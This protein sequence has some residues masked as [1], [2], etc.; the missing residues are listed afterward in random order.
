MKK[1]LKNLNTILDEKTNKLLPENLK[2]GVTL[3]G[4]EGTLESSNTTSGIIYYKDFSAMEA[5]KTQADG[6]L[7][8][9]GLNDAEIGVGS[10]NGIE[11]I[12][13]IEFADTIPATAIDSIPNDSYNYFQGDGLLFQPGDT[14]TLQI[15]SDNGMDGE[16]HITALYTKSGDNYTRNSDASKIYDISILTNY[17]YRLSKVYWESEEAKTNLSPY[18]KFKE[19][20]QTMVYVFNKPDN[21]WV[22]VPNTY[23]SGITSHIYKDEQYLSRTGLTTGT[24]DTSEKANIIT[25]KYPTLQYLEYKAMGHEPTL[26]EKYAVINT[27]NMPSIGDKRF[28]IMYGCNYGQSYYELKQFAVTDDL[29]ATLVMPSSGYTPNITTGT[30]GWNIYQGDAISTEGLDNITGNDLLKLCGK[31]LTLFSTMTAL[32]ILDSDTLENLQYNMVF[33]T[34][35]EIVNTEGVVVQPAGPKASTTL[36]GQYYINT[37]G[38]KVEGTMETSSSSDYFAADYYTNNP[39]GNNHVRNLLTTIPLVDTRV[40]KDFSYMFQGCTS[41]TTIPLLDMSNNINLNHTFEG[42]T[43]LTTIPLINTSKVTKMIMTFYNCYKLS[44]I[45]AIDTSKVTSFSQTFASCRKLVTVPQLDFSSATSS[46]SDI[47][48]YCTQL[49]DESLNNILASCIGAINVTDSNKTLKN[50][51]LTSS[52]ATKCTTLS[53]YEAFT[54]AGWTTGY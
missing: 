35:C 22:M 11:N 52:Q 50:I 33:I 5:D 46:L 26:T 9:V 40:V 27:L 38:E 34:N 13:L 39:S 42:C 17:S 25:V 41:L 43:S 10:S 28:V 37:F 21:S 1:L 7:C 53:N 45:P 48:Q 8:I 3:F 54:A 24:L 18:I 2:K 12:G 47:F 32:N 16:P 49:S 19:C 4:V 51:G 30:S 14:G 6:T 29:D 31:S 20:G 36:K 15:F 23:S 44:A